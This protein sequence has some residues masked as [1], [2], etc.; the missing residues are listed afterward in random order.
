M[1]TGYCA[2]LA[3]DPKFQPFNQESL[4]GSKYPLSGTFRFAIAI[5]II[6][7]PEN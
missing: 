2:L 4:Y 7:I 5:G 1:V 3:V 6:G